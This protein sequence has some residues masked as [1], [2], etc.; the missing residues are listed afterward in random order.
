M[1]IK[2]SVLNKS[3]RPR[4]R[5]LTRGWDTRRISAASRCLSRRAVMSFWTWIMRSARTNRCSASSRRNPTSRNTFP[6]DAVTLSCLPTLASPQTLELPLS[7][8]LSVPLSRE[9]DIVLRRFPAPLLESVQD[10]DC[11]PELCDVQDA[12][13]Q[14]GVDA[15]LPNAR[16]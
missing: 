16:S 7:D 1:S 5:S 12:V 14:S 10:V 9:I 13:L 6:V 4:R 3:M 2:A 11:F 15:D 8:Q